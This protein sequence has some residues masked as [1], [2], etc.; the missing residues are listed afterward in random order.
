MT[1]KEN[2]QRQLKRVRILLLLFIIG[3]LVSGATAFPLETEIDLLYRLVRHWQ[4]DN[5][6]SKWIITVHDG[7]HQSISKYSFIPYGT[8]WLAFAH[9]V[10]A[11]FFIRPYMNPIRDAWVID[12]GI[13]ACAAVFPMALVAG[14]IRG[15]PFFWQ[16]IDCSFGLFGGILLFYIREQ[17]K[18]LRCFRTSAFLHRP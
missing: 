15:I 16:L 13:A 14:N 18:R 6:F 8:D 2:Y 4:W 10:I 5:F 7:L 12:F 17:T 3:M 1:G 11:A 9:L